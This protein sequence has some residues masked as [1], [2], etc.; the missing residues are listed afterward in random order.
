MWV[1]HPSPCLSVQ[2]RSG[3]VETPDETVDQARSPETS[4]VSILWV[5]KSPSNSVVAASS[6]SWAQQLLPLQKP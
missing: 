6:G 2:H 4:P 1:Q 5:T 3:T